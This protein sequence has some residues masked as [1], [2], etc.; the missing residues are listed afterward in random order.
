VAHIA[1]K[2]A[3]GFTLIAGVFFTMVVLVSE[4]IM[5][6]FGKKFLA[7][8]SAQLFMMNGH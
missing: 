5:L 4:K 2:T 3:C 6:L 7:R 8:A 1:K